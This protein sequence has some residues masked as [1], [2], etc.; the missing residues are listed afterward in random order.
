MAKKNSSA[1]LADRDTS[2]LERVKAASQRLDDIRNDAHRQALDSELVRL[3]RRIEISSRLDEL[4]T[5]TG[6]LLGEL[7]RMD[8]ES[9]SDFNGDGLPRSLD[10][11]RRAKRRASALVGHIRDLAAWFE[12]SQVPGISSFNA[13]ADSYATELERYLSYCEREDEAAA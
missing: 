6:S 12:A 3:N 4:L 1:P 7:G 10:T 11:Q 5:E 9:W 8:V 2:Q 13:L